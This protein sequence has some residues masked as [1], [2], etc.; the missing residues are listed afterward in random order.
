MIDDAV[1][2]NE[3][4]HARP[5]ARVGGHIGSGHDRILNDRP[6]AAFCHCVADPAWRQRRLAPV[7]VFDASLTLLLLG[8]RELKSALKSLPNEDAQGNVQPIRRLY[9]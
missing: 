3:G 6:L 5:L 4:A 7:V 1:F 9:A 8:E 2:E